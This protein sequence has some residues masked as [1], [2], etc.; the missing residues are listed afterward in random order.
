[1]KMGTSSWLFKEKK[2]NDGLNTPTKIYLES[3]GTRGAEVHFK[4]GEEALARNDLEKALLEFKYAMIAYPEHKG[5]LRY[6]RGEKLGPLNVK[7]T[8]SAQSLFNDG[9]A[10]LDRKE[11][12]KAISCFDKAINLC[13]I[14]AVAS[15]CFR[16]KA[17]LATGRYQE[18]ID[19]LS[20]SLKYSPNMAEGYFDRGQ[21]YLKLGKKSEAKKDFEMVIELNPGYVE[22]R[23]ML[24]ELDKRKDVRGLIKALDHKDKDVRER[25]RE[26]LGRIGEPAVE[27]LIQALKDE[28]WYDASR[29]IALGLIG[30]PAVQPLIQVLNDEDVRLRRGAAEAAEAVGPLIRALTDKDEVVRMSAASALGS[31]GDA[32]ALEPL[33]HALN[34]EEGSV[35]WQAAEALGNVGDERAAEPLIQALKDK[36]APVRWAAAESLGRIGNEKALGP[37]R[38]ALY[39]RDYNVRKSAEKALETIKARIGT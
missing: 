26:S 9:M 38:E 34:D 18:A 24:E 5:A 10:L 3:Y 29:T 21:A 15:F 22:A 33:I 25:A 35:R 19:D 37:L 36:D 1:M 39:D 4:R 27:P 20:I 32:R 28:P 8:T 11:Y 6:L 13:P 16:G 14:A 31:I 7:R 2:I 17:F 23:E 12:K 30:K